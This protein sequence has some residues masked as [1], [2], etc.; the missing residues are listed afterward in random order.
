[1]KDYLTRNRR[2]KRGVTIGIR[3]CFFT[4]E[5]M[6]FWRTFWRALGFLHPEDRRT[7]RDRSMRTVCR[8][9]TSGHG[10]AS[11][12]KLV[13]GHIRALVKCGVDR[14][15]MPS[16]TTVSSENT[17]ATSQSMCAIVK[18]YPD[19]GAQFANPKEAVEYP[20]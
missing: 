17:E 14:I 18:G 19:R 2:R 5:T 4:G 6:P 9:V 10:P 1:M 16:I 7:A 8:R 3:R 13:H 12:Q 15:F 11:R 20:V